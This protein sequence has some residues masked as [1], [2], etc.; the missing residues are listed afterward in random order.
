[1]RI[2]TVSYRTNARVEPY[3]HRHIEAM[4]EVQSGETPEE[5]LEALKEWVDGQL[6]DVIETVTVKTEKVV[7]K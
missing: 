2:K 1:M 5:A 7:R 4:A 3:V 6:F